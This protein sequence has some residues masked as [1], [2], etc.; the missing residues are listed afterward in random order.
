MRAT[1]A[2][3]VGAAIGGQDAR[4]E[5][6]ARLQLVVAGLQLA[7]A[8]PRVAVLGLGEEADLAEVDAEDG[9]VH[10]GDR[11]GRAQERAVA[12][13]HDDG[14]GRRRGRAASRGTSPAGAA[15]AS[16][17]WSRHQRQRAFAQLR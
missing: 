1:C 2:A 7:P 5:H 8:R 4:L 15:Q 14:V 17:S 3:L 12:T 16:M 13:E 11:P 6:E 9:H 10:V